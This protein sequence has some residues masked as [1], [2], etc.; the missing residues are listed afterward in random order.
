M[1][2]LPRLVACLAVA[3]ALAAGCAGDM[4][5][6]LTSDPNLQARVMDLISGNGG[7]AGQMAD[8][9]LASD[10]TRSMVIDKLLA[11]GDGAQGVLVAVARNTTAL[12]GVIGLAVQDPATKEHLMTLFRGMEM[13]GGK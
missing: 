11:S 4:T 3:A 9:L 7:M 8:K 5:Q 6:Q 10:S 2:K 12:D 13:A 1:K